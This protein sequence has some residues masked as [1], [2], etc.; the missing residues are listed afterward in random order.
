M[1]D[2]ESL[3]IYELRE[4]LVRAMAPRPGGVRLV[5]EAPTGSGKSTQ[6]PRMLVNERLAGNGQV[7]VLQPR[8]LAARM[9]ARRVA[10]EQGTRLGEGV[11]FQV[12]FEKVVGPQTRIRYITEG[13]LLREMLLDPALGGIAAIIFDEFHERH[14][15]GDITLARALDVQ[16]SARPDLALLVMSAT[17]EAERLREYLAPCEFLRSAGR[18]HPVEIRYAP[19]RN[20]TEVSWDHA[21]RVGAETARA[22]DGN[23]LVF[24]PGAYEI[25]RTIEAI[26]REKWSRK[27]D[28]LPLHGEL[29]PADQDRAVDPSGH[30]KVIVSTNVAETSLTIEGVTGVID[31]GLARLAQFDAVRGINTLTVHKISQASAEQRAGRAGRTRPGICWRLWSEKDHARRPAQEAAEVHRMD[32]AEVLLTLLASGVEDLKK[33]RWVESPDAAAMEH[34]VELLRE[35]GAVMIRDGAPRITPLGHELVKYPVHPRHARILEAAR[36]KNC[37]PIFA[38]LIA[39]L[40]GRPLFGKAGAG[41]PDRFIDGREFSD[42]QPLLRAWEAARQCRFDRDQCAQLG[43]NAFAAGEAG[44]LA[45][46]LGRLARHRN[47]AGDG[48]TS[49][50]AESFG[51]ILLA[52]FPDQIARRASEGSLACDLTGRRRGQI[53]K[54][55]LVR[56]SRLIVASEVREVEGRQVQVVLNGVTAIEE[57]WLAEQFPDD[58]RRCT[59]V[60]WDDSLRRVMQKECTTIRDLVLTERQSGEPDRDKAAAILAAKVSTGE[61]RLTAWDDDVE[62]WITRL[63][64]LAQ[65]MPELDLPPLTAE[66]RPF[67]IEQLCHGSVSYK[68][69]K[70]KSPWPILRAWLNPQQAAWLE[71]YVPARFPLPDGRSAK[72]IYSDDGDPSLSA[73]IQQLYGLADTPKVAAGRV[74]VVVNILGPNMRPLQVTKDIVGFWKNHYPALKQEL[75]RKYPKHEWR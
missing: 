47:E 28:V 50:D 66:D 3:P 33:F 53:P 65:W 31:S 52:G 75:Q 26:R 57:S 2:A 25:R 17:L 16:A 15:Y 22:T 56:R 43:I 64:R 30:R 13:I 59:E 60:G 18:V 74:P 19:P 9:L 12:R 32:L 46:Q 27:F 10:A 7:V 54:E 38:L 41:A 6:I 21:A 23:L 24:M 63:N 70:E 48:V 1:P 36:A 51:R 58:Y 40:Q 55:S 8:R 69:I 37:V 67:I 39:L 4:A 71:E 45:A 61:L 62:Q 68:E 72:V 20:L 49:V 14:L 5:I 44:Q 35:L 42:L 29:P 73:R 34:A 11:G